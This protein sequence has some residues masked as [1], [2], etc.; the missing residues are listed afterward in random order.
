MD[1]VPF[2]PPSRPVEPLDPATQGRRLTQPPQSAFV[3]PGVPAQPRR[4]A[5]SYDAGVAHDAVRDAYGS[6]EGLARASALQHVL[7][8][9]LGGVLG[10]LDARADVDV[11]FCAHRGL[12]GA[13]TFGDLLSGALVGRTLHI[14]FWRC[15]AGEIPKDEA[16]RVAWLHD[17][18]ARVDAF[19]G[20]A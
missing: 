15:P 9:R 2:I 6:P 13:R 1:P 7:P 18:W 20:A 14:R 19:V 16:G 8:P 3:D 17:Q 4:A 11:V 10:L 12:S 5:D